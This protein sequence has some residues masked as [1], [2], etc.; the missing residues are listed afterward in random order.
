MLTTV[1]LQMDLVIINKWQFHHNA[2]RAQTSS[3]SSILNFTEFYRILSEY[4]RPL[5]CN[6]AKIGH[7]CIF[8][9]KFLLLYSPDIVFCWILLFN[10]DL[11]I[12][13]LLPHNY[14]WL[15]CNLSVYKTVQCHQNFPL[16]H[17]SFE[18][19]LLKQI[20]ILCKWQHFWEISW[21]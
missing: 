2:G 14:T 13:K 11:F 4:Y 15:M 10:Y 8:I 3:K 19:V 18:I 12:L 7:C 16:A 20:W 1:G 6:E 21:S 17:T 5:Y 9:L